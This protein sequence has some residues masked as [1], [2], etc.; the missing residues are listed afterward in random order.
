MKGLQ[1]NPQPE[2][3]HHLS[4]GFLLSSIENVRFQLLLEQFV[5]A[6]KLGATI[7]ASDQMPW[8]SMNIHIRNI[9]AIRFG[10][11]LV[12]KPYL[13]QLATSMTLIN[14]IASVI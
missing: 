8:F 5:T 3:K 2:E 6:T 4:R 14:A 9:E 1:R 11:L 7:V 10:C 12:Y 13:I